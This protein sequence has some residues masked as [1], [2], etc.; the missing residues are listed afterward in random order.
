AQPP[1]RA[2][3]EEMGDTL[4]S[5]LRKCLAGSFRCLPRLSHAACKAPALSPFPSLSP[6]FSS[7]L[8]SSLLLSPLLLSPLLLSSLLFSPLLLSSPLI[9]SPLLS[10]L[11]SL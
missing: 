3:N 9:S 8:L 10:S 4:R 2:A 5:N 7:L 1:P 11:F 6:H